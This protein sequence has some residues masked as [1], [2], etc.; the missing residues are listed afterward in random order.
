MNCSQISTSHGTAFGWQVA[1]VGNNWKWSAFAPSGS[2]GGVAASKAD[3]EA[4]A[5][6]AISRLKEQS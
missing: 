2:E 6:R 4:S 5:Q 1:P 3:A